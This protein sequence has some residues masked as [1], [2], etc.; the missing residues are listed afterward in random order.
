MGQV[1]DP[2]FHEVLFEMDAPDQPAGTVT[3]VLEAGYTHRRSAAASGPRRG[4]QEG[5][6]RRASAA[7]QDAAP[8]T[9]ECVESFFAQ[10]VAAE[11]DGPYISASQAG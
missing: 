6:S 10:P 8:T 4:G 7:S 1:F 2:N 11:T 3:Q 5:L 9:L